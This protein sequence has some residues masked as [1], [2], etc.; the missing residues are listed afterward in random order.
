MPVVIDGYNLY[1]FARGV[2]LEDGVILSLS[3]FCGIVEEW[4]GQSKQK[5]LIVF[6]GGAPPAM[7]QNQKQ[8]GVIGV[9]FTGQGSDADTFIEDCITKYSAPKL[10]TV[11]SSDL[12]IRKAA[13]RRHCKVVKSDEFWSKMAKKLM[14]KKPKPEP[15]AKTAGLLSHERDYW[16]KVFDIK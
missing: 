4:A 5:V 1:Y 12:R 15:R 16:L 9:E 3:V 6:D 2:Y 14:R 7:R 13:A 10:L 11:V 8:F